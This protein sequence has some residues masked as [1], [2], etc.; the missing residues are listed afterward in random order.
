MLQRVPYA[1]PAWAA[2]LT[3]PE[4]GRVRLGHLP[5]PIMPWN[6][7]ALRDLGVT[8][9]IKRDDM[10]GVEL[11]GNKVRKLEYLMAEAL[12][13]GHDSVVTVGG[14]QSNHCRATA[15][16]ARLVG[17]DAHLALLVSDRDA[18]ADPGLQGNL[19]LDRMLGATLHLCVASDYFRLGGDLAAMDKLN[20]IVADQLRAQGKN[21]YVVPV[22]GTCP[23]GAWGYLSA[24]DELTQQMSQGGQGSGAAEFDAIVFAAGSGGTATGIALGCRL[25][26]I[27]AEVHAVNVQHSPEVY[28]ASIQSEAEALGATV[29]RDGRSEQWLSLHD[30]GKIGYART[31]PE[32]LGFIR[33]VA[34]GSGVVLDHV[35]TGKALYQFCEEA[36]KE[37]ERWRGKRILFWHT[38]GLLGLYATAPQ[39]GELMP[40]AAVQRIRLPKV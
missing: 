4:N 16:A 22:G 27:P 14:L 35:Y 32:Q 40:K 8:W 20:E 19:L 31:D 26:Q 2:N 5:T 24:V 10:S 39:L 12:A 29:E 36:R 3:P 1:P 28:Y 17:L 30:G 11:S 34:A 6:C 38:G 25:A 7:P 23:L 13:K 18:D 33:E 37:P 9:L 21:P 15:A